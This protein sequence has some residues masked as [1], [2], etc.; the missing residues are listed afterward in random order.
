MDK[1]TPTNY[2]YL[3]LQPDSVLD[4]FNYAPPIVSIQIH[5]SFEILHFHV[6]T[7]KDYGLLECDNTQLGKKV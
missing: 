1:W 7:Y 4:G 6:G 2:F 3:V 5:K